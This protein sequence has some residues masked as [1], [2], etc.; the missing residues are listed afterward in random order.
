MERAAEEGGARTVMVLVDLYY[1]PYSAICYGLKHFPHIVIVERQ[2]ER[3][4]LLRDPFFEWEGPVSHTVLLQALTCEQLSAG[5]SLQAEAAQEPAPETVSALFREQFD[6]TSRSPLIEGVDRYMKQIA[7]G[8]AGYA[9]EALFA[10]IGQVGIVA[11]RWKAF[12]V[13]AGYF[14]E[15]SDASPDPALRALE[16]LLLRWEN[17]VLAIVRLGVLNRPERL[18]D[19]QDKLLRLE[20]LETEVRAELWKLFERWE[21]TCHEVLA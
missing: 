14:A 19:A 11:K 5:I 20:A 13:I 21:A 7:E 4:W 17:F 15:M 6:R 1:L 2:E 9:V 12:G 18:P 8:A 16:L 10:T 3:D